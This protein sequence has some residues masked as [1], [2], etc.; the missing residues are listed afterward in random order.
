MGLLGTLKLILYFLVTVQAC[1]EEILQE[2]FT[3]EKFYR[4]KFVGKNGREKTENKKD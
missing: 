1:I 3:G 2:N 4:K